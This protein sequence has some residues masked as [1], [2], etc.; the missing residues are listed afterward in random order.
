MSLTVPEMEILQAIEKNIESGAAYSSV[1]EIVG[2]LDNPPL[3]NNRNHLLAAFRALR[4]K[5][6]IDFEVGKGMRLTESGTVALRS[7]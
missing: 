2:E 3:E 4:S 1:E 7:V 5:G 6:F